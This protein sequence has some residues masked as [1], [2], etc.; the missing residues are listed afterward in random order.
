[1]FYSFFTPLY[2]E[3]NAVWLDTH[4]SLMMRTFF[5]VILFS[6]TKVNCFCFVP[7][8][9]LISQFTHSL[10]T[11]AYAVS[12]GWR[13]VLIEKEN[14]SITSTMELFP[15]TY[16][17][18]EKLSLLSLIFCFFFDTNSQLLSYYSKKTETPSIQPTQLKLNWNSSSCKVEDRNSILPSTDR[19][20]I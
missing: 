17:S 19:E 14:E 20:A 15:L 16:L 2:A 11:H 8:K 1:M 6:H 4:C 9:Y 18:S 10:D 13:F 7:Q 3:E 12:S 5:I